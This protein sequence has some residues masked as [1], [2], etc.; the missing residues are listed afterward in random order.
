MF[1][2]MSKPDYKKP[3]K[4]N[5]FAANTIDIGDSIDWE[6]FLMEIFIAFFLAVFAYQGYIAKLILLL[7]PCAVGS[8]VSFFISMRTLYLA[9]R[10]WQESRKSENKT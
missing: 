10:N 3:V 8:V 1:L 4:V 5:H 2:H 7:I 6:S 9:I